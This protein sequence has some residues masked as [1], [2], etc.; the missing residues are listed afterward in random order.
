MRTIQ[1]SI[2]V[3]E[4][5]AVFPQANPVKVIQRYLPFSN[6][7]FMLGLRAWEREIVI[8]MVVIVG[9]VASIQ[10][11]VGDNTAGIVDLLSFLSLPHT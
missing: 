11:A 9:L 4:L 8:L 7:T 1:D 10:I 6:L 2:V 5:K 3:S